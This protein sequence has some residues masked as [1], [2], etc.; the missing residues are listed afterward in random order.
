MARMHYPRGD[1]TYDS[2]TCSVMVQ[3]TQEVDAKRLPS[4]AFDPVG[5]GCVSQCGVR[6]RSRRA[7]L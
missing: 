7:R 5:K 2:L 1:A 6:G 4:R 3:G